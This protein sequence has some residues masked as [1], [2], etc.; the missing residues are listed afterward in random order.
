VI[1]PTVERGFLDV[2]FWSIE[3]R[4]QPLDEVDVGLVHLAEELAG[5]R[6]QR[7]DVPPL[8]LG[9]DRVERQGRL[10]RPESPV[11]T[12]RESR[13]RSRETSLRLC[14]RAPRMMS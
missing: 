7:L 2:D 4:R 8:A 3:T 6:R 1:V 11:N 9:E 10:A 12:M 13:G 14:S 5:V